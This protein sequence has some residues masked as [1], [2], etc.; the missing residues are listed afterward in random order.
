MLFNSSNYHVQTCHSCP[1]MPPESPQRLGCRSTNPAAR[2]YE[3]EIKNAKAANSDDGEDLNPA[4]RRFD[5]LDDGGV[6]GSSS[7]A[8]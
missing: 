7:L 4:A 2:I 3:H 5:Y 1:T 8:A 6:L